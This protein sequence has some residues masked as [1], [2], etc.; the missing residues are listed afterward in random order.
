MLYEEILTNVA[1]ISVNFQI[2]HELCWRI[3]SL[4]MK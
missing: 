4:D 1:Q 3:D 2:S